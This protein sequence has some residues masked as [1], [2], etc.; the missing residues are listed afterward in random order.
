MERSLADAWPAVA[1]PVQGHGL[2]IR[3]PLKRTAKVHD[4]DVT[5]ILPDKTLATSQVQKTTKADDLAA[6]QPDEC[7]ETAEAHYDVEEFE[8]EAQHWSSMRSADVK[9][10]RNNRFPSPPD[11]RLH[12][13]HLKKMD[14]L[15]D[16]LTMDPHLFETLVRNRR[17]IDGL[18][19]GSCIPSKGMHADAQD[20]EFL[21][22]ISP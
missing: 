7:Q 12:E 22:Y 18:T 20:N 16:D 14:R 19:M 17:C 1:E 6:V 10:T 15:Q 11:R 4:L 2:R 9:A 21:K 8:I 13:Q 5:A 3:K